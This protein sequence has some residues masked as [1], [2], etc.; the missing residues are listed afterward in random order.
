MKI[1]KKSVFAIILMTILFNLTV[2]NNVS[3]LGPVVIDNWTE[4]YQ[5]GYQEGLRYA[6]MDWR[7]GYDYM[8]NHYIHQSKNC[9][10]YLQSGDFFHHLILLS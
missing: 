9:K 2:V 6:E 7:S 3:A 10:K 8:L 5:F 1:Q 4:D